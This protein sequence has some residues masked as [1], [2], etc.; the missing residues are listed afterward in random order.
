MQNLRLSLSFRYY[1]KETK[2]GKRE[3]SIQ[4]DIIKEIEQRYPNCIVLKNDAN[5]KQGIPDLTIFYRDKYAMLETKKDKDARY[6]P[7]QET[8]LKIVDH[9]SFARRI[10]PENKEEVLNELD[11]FFGV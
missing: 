3:N 9:W 1:R 8:Y 2:M 4:P 7:N 11:A 5:Y 10:E 6:R